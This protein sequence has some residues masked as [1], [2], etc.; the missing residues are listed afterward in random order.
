MSSHKPISEH[1][2]ELEARVLAAALRQSFELGDTSGALL[3]HRQLTELLRQSIVPQTCSRLDQTTDDHTVNPSDSSLLSI[4]K[5]KYASANVDLKD[6][7]AGQPP[8]AKPE[9]ATQSNLTKTFYDILNLDPMTS[10][11]DI[12]LA[13]LRQVRRLIKQHRLTKSVEIRE[14]RHT[15]QVLWVAHDILKDPAT[16]TDYDFRLLGLR[17][18]KPP[19]E[20]KPASLTTKT[21]LRIGELL[22]CAQMLEPQELEI[23]VDMHKAMSELYFGQFLVK[24]G[25]LS[26]DE[27]ASALLGQ[28][29]IVAGKLTVTQFQFAMQL[30]R[31]KAVPLSKTLLQNGWVLAEDLVLSEPTQ[32][33]TITNNTKTPEAVVLQA[34]QVDSC[35]L[36]RDPVVQSLEEQLTSAMFNNSTQDKANNSYEQD[37]GQ[38]TNFDN[39]ME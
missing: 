36:E 29:L 5:S 34:G 8:I 23:V 31:Q 37:P 1:R 24:Q 16:R 26:E 33:T 35:L 11:K 15:L 14:F 2:N 22:Q 9:Q 39:D 13:F 17:T 38:S 19:E 32:D 3:A 30:V 25:F 12:H 20:T 10:F 28:R 6:S 21:P 4:A 7:P 18:H 27:L